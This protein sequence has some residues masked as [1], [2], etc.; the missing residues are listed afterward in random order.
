MN[1]IKLYEFPTTRYQGSKRK[2]LPW[3]YSIVKDLKFETALDVFGGSSSVSYLFKKMNKSVT[4]NDKLYFNHL[5]G[6]AIIENGTTKLTKDD[7]SYLTSRNEEINYPNFIQN[8]FKGIYYHQKE[9][10]W[11][12]KVVSNIMNMNHHQVNVLQ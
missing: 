1:E 7:L 9:N 12:D 10:A 5:I 8:T 11:L 2:I 4:Y 6:K 3:I